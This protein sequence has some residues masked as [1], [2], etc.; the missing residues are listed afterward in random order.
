MCSH[1]DV[2]AMENKGVK[3]DCAEGICIER[4][5]DNKYE[6]SIF[7]SVFVVAAQ[8]TLEGARC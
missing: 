6:Q 2:Q 1:D 8:R 4:K 5:V 7:R 3:S